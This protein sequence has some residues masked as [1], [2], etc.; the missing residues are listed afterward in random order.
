[1]VDRKEIAAPGQVRQSLNSALAPFAMLGSDERQISGSALQPLLLG[2]ND[3]LQ[4]SVGPLSPGTDGVEA[5]AIGPR[6]DVEPRLAVIERADADADFAE[7][8]RFLGRKF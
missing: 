2:L 6:L 8:F 3:Q 4:R 5:D 1:M 7:H